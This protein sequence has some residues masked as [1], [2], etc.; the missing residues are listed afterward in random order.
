MTSNDFDDYRIHR[1]CHDRR[2]TPHRSVLLGLMASTVFSTTIFHSSAGPG[3]MV[4]SGYLTE[5]CA[6][7]NS[8]VNITV[9]C[10]P[11][12]VCYAAGRDSTAQPKGK[13]CWEPQDICQVSTCIMTYSSR[14]FGDAMFCCCNTDMCNLDI[15]Y[16]SGIVNS[17]Q[18]VHSGITSSSLLI[19]HLYYFVSFYG[20][21]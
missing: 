6:A 4:C 19:L 13:G 17:T 11:G 21:D 14:E 8:C 7:S 15:R 18:P 20:I 5:D 16:K 12:Q 1:G 9:P 3:M 10:Q 2:D